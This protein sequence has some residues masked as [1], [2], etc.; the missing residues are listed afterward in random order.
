MYGDRRPLDKAIFAAAVERGFALV[1]IKSTPPEYDDWNNSTSNAMSLFVKAG[2][3]VIAYSRIVT[4]GKTGSSC[5]MDWTDADGFDNDLRRWN[6]W[7]RDH[8]D[9]T[10]SKQSIA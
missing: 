8:A 9:V 3:F 1:A 7:D 6:E 10:Q 4:S 2:Q 5:C